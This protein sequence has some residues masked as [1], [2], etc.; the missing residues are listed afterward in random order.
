[1]RDILPIV[2]RTRCSA[3]FHKP[4]TFLSGLSS[5]MPAGSQPDATTVPHVQAP[6]IWLAMGD[7]TRRK[8]WFSRLRK[9]NML[10]QG[11]ATGAHFIEQ[12]GER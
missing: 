5:M 11:A 7:F 1:M 10:G 9:R 3:V 4:P 12:G 8:A 6:G 2:I